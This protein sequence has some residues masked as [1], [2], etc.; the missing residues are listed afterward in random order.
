MD[1][2][3]FVHISEPLGYLKCDCACLA[4]R[5]LPGEVGLQVTVLQVLHVDIYLVVDL[6]PAKVLDKRIAVLEQRG[7]VSP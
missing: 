4:L 5:E 6:I 7:R 3:V 2:V 1:I